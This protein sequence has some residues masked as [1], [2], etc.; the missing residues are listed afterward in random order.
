MKNFNPK[1]SIIIPVYNGSNYL[2]EAIDSAL[3]QTYKNVEIIVVNDGSNDDGATD[4]IAKSYGKKIRYFA[5]EN[6]GTATALNL[7]ISKMKGS[8][9]S[10][11]SHDDTYYPKKI[12]RQIEEL[13]KLENKNTIMMTDLDG[14]DENYEKIYETKYIENIQKYPLREKSYLYPVIYNQTHGCVLLIPKICFDEVGLFDEK[15]LVAQD[16]EFFYRVF[17]KFPHKLI[18]E[19]LVTARDSRNRQGRRSK[20][21]G[22]VEYSNLYIKMIKNLKKDEIELLAPTELD[23]YLDMLDLFHTA[24]YEKAWEFIRGKV[25]RNIQISSHDVIGNKFNG[26]DL[27]KYLREKNVDSKQYVLNQESQ[28]QETICYDFLAKD[29]TK[30]FMLRKDF[31]ETDILHLHLVHNILDLNYLPIIT[32]LKPT[33][34]TLH[35]PFFLG[36]HC[37]HHFD[38][39]KWQTHCEDCPYLN[40]PFPLKRDY[41]ALNYELKKQAIQNSQI[42]AIVASKWMEN[43]VK[44]SPIWKDKKI[45]YLPFGIDQKIFRSEDI[46]LAK[47]RLH[48]K[49]DNLV[50]MF[51]ADNG[52]YKGLDIIKKA[53]SSIKDS[54]KITLITTDKKGLLEEYKNKFKILEYGWVSDDI[55]LSNLYQA[56]DIFLMPSRQETFG[57][58]AIEAMSCGKMVLAIKGKGTAVPDVIGSPNYGIAVE[59]EEYGAELE[60]LLN[61]PKEIK[62]R[63]E[64]SLELA[65]KNFSKEVYVNGIIKIYKEIILNHK[66]DKEAELIIEQLKKHMVGASGI[67][68]LEDNSSIINR[69]RRLNVYWPE[70]SLSRRLY[71]RIIPIGIRRN[72]NNFLGKIFHLIIKFFPA[73]IKH[74][75]SKGKEEV[76]NVGPILIFPKISIIIPVYNGSDYLKEAIDSAIAQTY[77]NVEVIV[78]NDGSNDN[79]KTEKICKSYGNKIKYFKKENGG[80]A[81]ALNMGVEKME[82]EYFSWL[83]HDDVYYPNKIEEQ[84]KYLS[85]I[86]DRDNV[87]LYNDYEFIDENSNSFAKIILDHNMLIKKPEYS[88]LRGS[89]NG[90]TLLIPKKAFDDYGKFKENLKTTQ[91]YD[92][93]IRMSKTYKFMHM[94]GILTKTRI[95]DKQDSKKHPDFVREGNKL[96]IKMME[97]IS[98]E[99][100]KRLEG[101]EYGF[102]KGILDYLKAWTPY[103]GAIKY[104]EEKIESVSFVKKG[105]YLIRKQGLIQTTKNLLKKIKAKTI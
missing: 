91:D 79:G 22:N 83:S 29:A 45:Y 31:Y 93:W 33:V 39:N 27:H 55:I 103:N 17:S 20:A 92:M 60:R 49:E 37:V 44:K 72:I 54:K 25:I 62:I 12:Q 73:V 42:T 105:Y 7:G 58:M 66:K 100:K 87:I 71:R 104:A 65:R 69:G 50:L 26:H 97:K 78:I 48:I 3:A 32:R 40:E 35:D 98:K 82:G 4:K 75:L 16:F 63:G 89:I 86:P 36:G 51:R 34:I 57:M 64:K 41:S 80:V 76:T 68:E 38:C 101:S 88:L 11:L 85:N 23:F 5:K 30:Y 43:K 21:R 102:Y 24:G 94:E 59:E 47:R 90:I 2:N 28:D 9:F 19:I 52:P 81:S 74:R 95:H 84:V 67:F 70:K 6:G 96:W 13:S 77:K 46:K 61:N 1:V 18:P 53:L 56:C 8:Y 10:W 15:E 99:D 14:I